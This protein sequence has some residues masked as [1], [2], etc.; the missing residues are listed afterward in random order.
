LD[1][2][3]N[4]GAGGGVYWLYSNGVNIS[5]FTVFENWFS[6]NSAEY[7]DDYATEEAF[8]EY[9]PDGLSS[10]NSNDHSIINVS[11]TLTSVQ[12]FVVD[13]YS[14]RVVTSSDIDVD[15]STVKESTTCG[16]SSLEVCGTVSTTVSNGIA[17]FDSFLLSCSVGDQIDLEFTTS[18]TLVTNTIHLI[19]QFEI[20]VR[21]QVYYNSS[22]V[23]VTCSEGTYRL[24]NFTS[25][26]L[27]DITTCNTC[28]ANAE[29][30]SDIVRA[31]PGYW[32]VKTFDDAVMKCPYGEA[33]CP[34]RV[35]GGNA[36]CN[37]GK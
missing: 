19:F 25:T 15:W 11:S 13:F 33:A 6:G 4:L 21:G 8:L 31:D 27:Q 2:S 14:Q 29:C 1:N 7:G 23:C 28:P 30:S 9:S 10:L 26:N 32:K 36:A 3:V 18:S 34:G 20:C 17:S 37:E 16:G 22:D 35:V 5:N 24:D 12:L